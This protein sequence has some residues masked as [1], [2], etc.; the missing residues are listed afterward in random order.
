MT[1][2]SG[3]IRVKNTK[4]P[5]VLDANFVVFFRLAPGFGH[6]GLGTALIPDG[7]PSRLGATPIGRSVL[8]TPCL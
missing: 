8:D 1:T 5:C 6:L 2:L 4:R 7:L 3:F